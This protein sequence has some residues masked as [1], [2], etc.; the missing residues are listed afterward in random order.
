MLLAVAL[1][2]SPPLENDTA[3]H[4][5][6]GLIQYIGGDYAEAVNEE[7]PVEL[8]EQ[9]RLMAEATAALDALGTVGEPYRPL[10]KSLRARVDEGV[11]AWG[12]TAGCN[13]LGQKILIEQK[14]QRGPRKTPNL[15]RGVELWASQCALC[16]GITGDAQTP[17]AAG[18]N[19]RP[20]NFHDADK[21]IW[22]TP[23]RAFNTS[24]FGVP[25]TAMAPF[26]LLSE[27]D[28]WSLAFHVFTLHQLPCDH[29]APFASLEELAQSTDPDL[30]AKFGLVEVSCLRRRLPDGLGQV[31]GTR[32]AGVTW[33]AIASAWV[34]LGGLLFWRLSKSRRST[35]GGTG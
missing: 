18:L 17:V 29:V 14:L 2:A 19:P 22:L 24:T 13:R 4:R 9:R 3:W 23:Y 10:L 5:L 32:I 21:T 6:V 11:D 26:P 35:P 25:G 20:A 34:V 30:A 15:A 7:N 8:A 28:R 27:E 12:V 16:H 31:G 1:T 33:A